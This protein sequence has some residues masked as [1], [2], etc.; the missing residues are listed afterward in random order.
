ME[1]FSNSQMLLPNWRRNSIKRYPFKLLLGSRKPSIMVIAWTLKL[2]EVRIFYDVRRHGGLSS[3]HRDCREVAPL[4]TV[5]LKASLHFLKAPASRYWTL[6]A[7]RSPGRLDF[8]SSMVQM[9]GWSFPISM[10]LTMALVLHRILF[11]IDF[12]AYVL[13]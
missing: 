13:I 6:V 12:V 11:W 7:G 10:R 8:G 2:I 3:M 1:N 4:A 9:P 5:R